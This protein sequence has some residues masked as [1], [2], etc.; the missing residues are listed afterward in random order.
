MIVLP[1]NSV[2]NPLLYDKAAR[3]FFLGKIRVLGTKII[4]SKIAFFIRQLTITRNGIGGEDYG[5]VPVE[6]GRLEGGRK[7][8]RDLLDKAAKREQIH[9]SLYRKGKHGYS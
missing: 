1:I 2:I 3:E 7:G 9:S 8:A 4:N 6:G 5:S